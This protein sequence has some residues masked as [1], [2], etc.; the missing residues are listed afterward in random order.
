MLGV[1][2]VQAPRLSETFIALELMTL[3]RRGVPL[4][5]FALAPGKAP[6]ALLAAAREATDSPTDAESCPESETYAGFTLPVVAPPGGALSRVLR[7]TQAHLVLACRRPRRYIRLFWRRVVRRSLIRYRASRRGGEPMAWSHGREFLLA[8]WLAEEA[9]AAGVTHLHAHYASGPAT[10]ALT[11]HELTGLPMSFTAHAKDAYSASRRRLAKKIAA[12]RFVVTCSN[13]VAAYLRT[14]APARAEGIRVIH[15]GVSPEVLA[16]AA[17]NATNGRGPATAGPG[18]PSGGGRAADPPLVLAAGRLVEKK[19]FDDLMRAIAILHARGIACRAEIV[20]EGRLKSTLLVLARELGLDGSVNF[21]GALPHDVLARRY[22]NAACFVMPSRV[23]DG[24]NRDG[25]PNVLLEAMAAGVPAVATTVGG[26]PE[27]LSPGVN[28]LLAAADDPASL[29]DRIAQVLAEPATAALRAERARE[30]VRDRFDL[31]RNVEQL[32][33]EFQR[34]GALPASRSLRVGYIVKRYPRLSETFILNEILEQERQGTL[35]HIVSL[36]KPDEGRFHADLARVKA[37]VT[38][39]PG[40]IVPSLKLI[41]GAN[42]RWL[43][44]HP[45]RY[46]ATFALALRGGDRHP[47]SAFLK[48]SV[49]ADL[50]VTRRLDLLH[51]HFAT[52]ATFMAM[53]VSRL[54]GVPYGFTAHARDLYGAHIDRSALRRKVEH[55]SYVVVVS[56]ETRDFLRELVGPELGLRVQRIYNGVHPS[57]LRQP[58]RPLAGGA[59]LLLGVGRLVEKKGFSHLLAAA[60]RLQERG[61]HC[62]LA[63]AGDGPLRRALEREAVERGLAVR[64][65][66]ALPH[67]QVAAAMRGARAVVLPA[68]VAAD[69]D[70]DVLPTVLLEAQALGRPVVSTRLTG[71][72]EIVADGVSG[73]LVPADDTE[74]LVAGLVAALSRLLDDRALAARLGA[75]GRERIVKMFDPTANVAA[76]AA[77]MRSAVEAGPLAAPAARRERRPISGAA[78]HP[79]PVPARAAP[80]AMVARPA[81]HHCARI[82][83]RVVTP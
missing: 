59:P 61:I 36:K 32:I 66:G 37:G 83:P 1:I 47:L 13:S 11:V 27:V 17:T 29:A 40:Y 68:I 49:A 55:A 74:A 19:G 2:L 14:L 48:A 35:V 42:A 9:R 44:C 46:L 57:L 21:T 23:L 70:R 24:G 73:F 10:V 34:A 60:T 22:G 20:G 65:L 54:T 3:A 38:Y 62:R 79:L 45:R 75:A 26:I 43:R 31:A 78:P 25:I 80:A 39:L 16:A 5:V 4:R 71:I 51:A 7:F 58:A 6:D 28:G 41:I 77:L 76:L 30:T 67:E 53:L 50:A 18:E 64:F 82:D 33:G 69:G 12:A 15:H 72:P 56:D 8:G 81:A 63:I 52:G